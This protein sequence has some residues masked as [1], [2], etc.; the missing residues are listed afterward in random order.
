MLR[1]HKNWTFPYFL[2][3][4]A[5][6]LPFLFDTSLLYL[7]LS[8]TLIPFFPLAVVVQPSVVPA[9]E[10]PTCPLPIFLEEKSNRGNIGGFFL[11]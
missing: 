4:Y 9:V 5:P 2:G 8:H 6:E 3:C 1:T 10:H 7:Y 11:E